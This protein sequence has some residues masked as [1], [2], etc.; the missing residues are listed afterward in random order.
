M[1]S[2]ESTLPS[3]TS[4]FQRDN[5]A[6]R[7]SLPRGW[8]AHGL[9]RICG[10]ETALTPRQTRSARR[11]QTTAELHDAPERL[12]TGRQCITREDAAH[13]FAIAKR[14]DWFLANGAALRALK[15]ENRS[16]V[17]AASHLLANGSAFK[18]VHRFGEMKIKSGFFASL[19]IFLPNQIG[20]YLASFWLIRS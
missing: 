20:C 2:L 12:F 15:H 13:S 19:N 7:S 16:C 5:A 17:S 3:P 10:P 14:E 8:R 1:R 18:E 4:R 11:S 6:R 9:S